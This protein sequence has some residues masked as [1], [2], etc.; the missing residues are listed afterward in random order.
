MKGRGRPSIIELDTRVCS[1]EAIKNASY[2]FSD[3]AESFIE[4]ISD[5]KTRVRLEALENSPSSND[6]L[7]NEFLGLALDHQV[8]LD[9][10]K[11]Y[12]LIREMIV[13]QAFEPVD[14]LDQVVETLKP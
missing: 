12:K 10:A 2:D 11:D 7:V 3:K 1:L 9:V 8:R 14:N 5:A 6:C 13:A 4:V